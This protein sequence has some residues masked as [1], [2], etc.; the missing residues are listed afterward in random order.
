ME[1]TLMT[2]PVTWVGAL[3]PGSP[4]SMA[5]AL[6]SLNLHSVLVYF[7]L[8]LYLKHAADASPFL[9]LHKVFI[10]L[11]TWLWILPCVSS[12]QPGIFPLTTQNYRLTNAPFAIA[13]SIF[14]NILAFSKRCH[15][16]Y[17]FYLFLSFFSYIILQKEYNT[18]IIM[19]ILLL[20]SC[21]LNYIFKI[22]T[23]PTLSPKCW[24]Y[25]RILLVHWKIYLWLQ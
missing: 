9:F 10:N 18:N 13:S 23:L 21:P 8:W 7:T 22:L 2:V 14:L 5:D 20:W 6:C 15:S 24:H 17:L 25:L 12:Y 4:T 1:P 19:K 16:W 3:L 11:Y